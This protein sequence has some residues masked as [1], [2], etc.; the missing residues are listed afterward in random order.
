MASTRTSTW[1]STAKVCFVRSTCTELCKTIAPRLRDN[2]TAARGRIT[3]P[4]AHC[5]V[6]SACTYFAKYTALSRVRHELI[7][8][9]RKNTFCP[10]ALYS[11]SLLI[12]IISDSD[13]DYDTD[14]NITKSSDA[15][16]YIIFCGLRKFDPEILQ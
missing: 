6:I 5:F 12:S 11:F 3:Q 4:R 2:A 8:F 13:A 1:K 7:L 15:L 9:R 10:S 14:N 16:R